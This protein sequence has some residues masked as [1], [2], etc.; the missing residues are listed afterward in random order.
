[1]P[2]Q[3]L[4]SIGSMT[5]FI[6]IIREFVELFGQKI[7]RKINKQTQKFGDTPKTKTV[8]SLE[9]TVLEIS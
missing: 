7:T 2:L 8:N 9:L 1:M 5:T 3:I 6:R 4:E